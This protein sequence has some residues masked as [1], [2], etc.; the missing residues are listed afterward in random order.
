MTEDDPPRAD[1]TPILELDA[2]TLSENIQL[3]ISI[4]VRYPEMAKTPLGLLVKVLLT[5]FTLLVE[6]M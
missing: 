5:I 3:L 2:C 6:S 1:I 4:S